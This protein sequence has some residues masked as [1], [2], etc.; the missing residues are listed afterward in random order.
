[1]TDEISTQ[2]DLL[3]ANLPVFDAH[4]GSHSLNAWD[5]PQVH[6]RLSNPKRQVLFRCC[7]RLAA[8]GLVGADL[9][10]EYIYGK[11]INNLSVHTIRQSGY[12]VLSFLR[13]LSLVN[14]NIYTLTRQNISAFVDCGQYRGLKIQ[15]TIGYLR[16]LYAFIAFLVKQEI[17]SH[18]IM[19][20]KV[21]IKQPDSL[22]RAI[23]TEDIQ[24]LLEVL[25]NVRDRAMILLLLRTGMRIG[26]LLEVK[27]NDISFS[28]RKIL[29]YQGEKNYQGR[30]VYYSKDAEHAL[31]EWLEIRNKYTVHLFPGQKGRQLSYSTA[32]NVMRN[33]LKRA[34]L[35]H[36][37]YSLHSLR[38]TFATDMLNAGMRLE[39]LQQ[40]L[41]HQDI[42]ITMKYARMADRTREYEY[43][44]A[45]DT[46]EHGR[47]Y[48]PYRVSD[49]LQK[50][51]EEK[52]LLRSHG[53]KL[54]E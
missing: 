14:T 36:K 52:K 11:Y 16:A 50:V 4:K 53:K 7:S 38:H 41:G 35:C 3:L 45:M 13:S 23:S 24:I 21:R 30:A 15:S 18:T 31:Q 6:T 39:V 28:E 47:H 34:D 32:W 26:E 46:I 27:I 1:M 5:Y 42:E 48:E 54:P 20:N 29:I 22:P 33:S 40:L 51:F 12:V 25:C 8:S 37:G 19:E 44:K 43:F 9:G 17:L 2:K 49:Q 10:V